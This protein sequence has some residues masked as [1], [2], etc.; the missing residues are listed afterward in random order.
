MKSPFWFFR[1]RGGRKKRSFV[2][3]IF[4]VGVAALLL[5][6]GCASPGSNSTPTSAAYSAA[7]ASMAANC[8][9]EAPLQPTESKSVQVLLPSTGQGGRPPGSITEPTSLYSPQTSPLGETPSARTVSGSDSDPQTTPASL[10]RPV[11]EPSRGYPST[12][13][14]PTDPISPP[15]SSSTSTLS[16]IDQPTSAPPSSP[17]PNGGGADTGVPPVDIPGGYTDYTQNRENA[18]KTG[19]PPFQNASRERSSE[20]SPAASGESA[21]GDSPEASG[22]ASGSAKESPNFRPVSSSLPSSSGG[23]STGSTSSGTKPSEPKPS[24]GATATEIPSAGQGP[25]GTFGGRPNPAR[26][27]FRTVIE[28]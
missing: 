18:G 27:Q 5:L 22:S 9:E 1:Q 2:G 4:G 23:S 19:E 15:P 28:K 3:P 16:P 7:D 14:N 8:S 20:S 25:T 26:V 21:P 13:A 24:G 12:T 11:A 6:G 10:E 17:S